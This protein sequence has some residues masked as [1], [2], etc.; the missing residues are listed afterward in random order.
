VAGGYATSGAAST[1]TPVRTEAAAGACWSRVPRARTAARR[2]SFRDKWSPTVLQMEAV[3]CGAASLAMVLAFYRKF[4]PLE[5]LR[6][7][8]GVSRDGCKAS[9]LVKA[10]RKYGVVARGVQMGVADLRAVPTPAILF[11]EFNH[12]VVYDGMRNRFGRPVVLVNDPA[13]GRRVIPLAEFDTSFTGIVLTFEPGPEFL[14]GGRRPRLTTGMWARVRGSTT[15]LYLALCASL[16]LVVLGAVEP[17]FTRAYTDIVLFDH[18]SSILRGFFMTMAGVIAAAAVLTAV[19]QASLLR[20]WLVSSTLSA[21]RFL[22]HLLKLPVV[23]FIQRNPADL[24]Q[25][26][27]SNDRVARVFSRDLADVAINLVVVFGYALMLW[28]Y[29]PKLTLLGI[30]IALLNILALRVVVRLRA[31]G[32]TKLRIDTAR[33]VSTSYAGVQLIETLK[34]GGGENGY[35]RRWAGQQATT[36]NGHQRLGVPGSVLAVVAPTLAAIN[37]GLILLVGGT[38]AVDG[39]ISI[40]SLLAFQALVTSF[41]APVTQLTL[42]AG[43]VQDFAA[44]AARLRD[45]EAYP[46]DRGFER[47]QAV[48]THRLDGHLVMANVTFGYNPV[49]DPV[50]RDLSLSVGPGEQIALVGASGS[51][52]ST[53]IRLISGLVQPWSGEVRFDGYLPAQI[54]RTAMS[55]SVAFVDQDIF[56]FEGTVRDNVTLWDPSIPDEAVFAALKDAL[57]YDMVAARPGGLYS[58]VEQDGR[59]FSGGQRQRLEIARAL[60]RHPSILVLDE[61]TSALDAETER[62]ISDNLRQRGCACIVIA[63]R[64]STIHDSD[65]ILVLARGTVVE[66]GRHDQLVAAGGVYAGLIRGPL[67]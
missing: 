33:L 5:E 26:L 20:S 56:L 47:E 13:H 41:T 65:E 30:A 6:A 35:F 54:T 44:D 52:K 1:A 15:S 24:S 12:F 46:V 37:S 34:A 36:V 38:R 49:A 39:R 42:L 66:R 55:A 23:F 3:E 53:V 58:R 9:G 25:R 64:L 28:M 60:V 61:A 4:V 21:A 11:W 8:C 62:A 22:D 67:A 59:N 19:E 43:E 7:A 32:V 48:V 63:H 57:A 17:A 10:A 50:V 18:D 45:V 2:R 27:A 29:D 16:L 40:G 14:P 31:T 51:G